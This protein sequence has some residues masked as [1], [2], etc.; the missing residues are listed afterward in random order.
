MLVRKKRTIKW[1]TDELGKKTAIMSKWYTNVLYN[2]IRLQDCLTL[3][4]KNILQVQIGSMTDNYK[5]INLSMMSI[6]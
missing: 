3:T 1:L 5:S 2:L 4:Y 6:L